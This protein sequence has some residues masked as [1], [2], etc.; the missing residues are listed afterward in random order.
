MS[1][2]VVLM[3]LQRKILFYIVVIMVVLSFGGCQF[4]SAVVESQGITSNAR[5]GDA[6]PT[7]QR[8]TQ[9]KQMLREDMPITDGSTSA[10]PLDAAIRAGLFDISM[11]E[12]QAQVSHSTSHTAF[13]NLLSRNCELVF[14]HLLSDAQYQQA[15]TAGIAIEQ[16]PI[17]REGFVFLVS[18]ENPVDSLTAEQIKM[19]YAGKITNWSEVGGNDEPIIPYQRNMDS[20]SQ[21]YM[22]AFMGEIP[23]MQAPT[24]LRPGSMDTLVDAI[25]GYDG[26]GGSIGYSVYSYV[27]GMYDADGGVKILKVN[28]VAPS[29]AAIA[30]GSYPCTGYNYAVIRA[31]EP[32]DSPAGLLLEYI[33]SDEG[34]QAIADTGYF[35]PLDPT[36]VIDVTIQ[37]LNLYVQTGTG[38][39]EYRRCAWYY[40]T[41]V[42]TDSLCIPYA[43]GYTLHGRRYAFDTR[44]PVTGNPALDAEVEAYLL[45]AVCN[46]V[47]MISTADFNSQEEIPTVPI[48]FS[49]TQV[50]GYLSVKVTRGTA[51]APT[52]TYGAIW[53]IDTGKRLSLSDLFI[54]Q[55]DFIQALN[56]AVQRRIDYVSAFGEYTETIYPF[57]GIEADFKQFS[58]DRSNLWGEITSRQSLHLNLYFNDGENSYFNNNGCTSEVAVSVGELEGCL[59]AEAK[60]MKHY[61]N[62]NQVQSRAYWGHENVKLR[63][64]SFSDDTEP[65]RYTGQYRWYEIKGYPGAEAINK[66]YYAFMKSTYIAAEIALNQT[67]ENCNLKIIAE[68]VFWGDRYVAI[69][70]YAQT[71]YGDFIGYGGG[72]ISNRTLAVYDLQTG[73]QVSAG[74]LF[75]EKSL[76]GEWLSDGE[77][78]KAPKMLTSPVGVQVANDHRICFVFSSEDKEYACIPYEESIAWY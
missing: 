34:Q 2:L 68:P 4:S 35:A 5:R 27:G 37:N 78:C 70:C 77:P 18:K 29:A 23:L 76:N 21:N 13:T 8:I 26:A 55:S 53:D 16:T 10:I 39:R 44:R 14:C 58:L 32:Q 46:M 9:L 65:T 6:D 61:L 24:A 30:D 75:S 25:A 72:I 12:A 64:E 62:E 71:Q 22:S 3:Q 7:N 17:A 57:E 20:G 49:F 11:D 56:A 66:E 51:Y 1:D 19:I 42:L 50:N 52:Y 47:E 43:D 67:V 31:D 48:G 60:D 63:E 74:V 41:N 59:L 33:L 36:A 28:E 69:S 38:K 54:Y 73:E 45:D 40:Q 15:E